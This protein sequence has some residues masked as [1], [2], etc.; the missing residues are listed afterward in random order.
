MLANKKKESEERVKF[1]QAENASTIRLNI[2]RVWVNGEGSAHIDGR[3]GG[4][5]GWHALRLCTP[6]A[7]TG[8]FGLESEF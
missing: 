5:S 7:G 4:R 2:L 1:E 8:E 6:I 3:K